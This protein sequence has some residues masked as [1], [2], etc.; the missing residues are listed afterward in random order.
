MGKVLPFRRKDQEPEPEKEKTP[1]SGVTKAEKERTLLFFA[2]L[3]AGAAT[4][5]LCL[6]AL[7]IGGPRM[8]FSLCALVVGAAAL[9]ALVLYREI[10]AGISASV[11]AAGAAS[12]LAGSVP[13]FGY[14]AHVMQASACLTLIGVAAYLIVAKRMPP[15]VVLTPAAMQIVLLWFL[16]AAEKTWISVLATLIAGALFFRARSAPINEPKREDAPPPDE[17]A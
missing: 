2:P 5:A 17:A 1:E 6:V 7:E 13:E 16:F 15:P 8:A 4:H 14:V 10:A 12:A 3:F 9:V 11:M